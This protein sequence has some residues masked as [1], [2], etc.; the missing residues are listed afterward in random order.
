[1]GTGSFMIS[2]QPLEIGGGDA[3]RAGAAIGSG[4]TVVQLLA[5]EDE[6]L[7]GVS[8]PRF[9][10]MSKLGVELL[11]AGLKRPS[12]ATGKLIDR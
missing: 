9:D 6:M 7:S 4:V 1:M 12:G 11:Y 10:A 5:T 3:A 8:R 2:S